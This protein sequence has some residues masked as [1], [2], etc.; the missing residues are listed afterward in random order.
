MNEKLRCFS[1]RVSELKC[2]LAGITYSDPKYYV[3]RNNSDVAVIEYVRSGTGYIV[4]DGKSVEVGAGKVYLLCM[5]ENQEYYSDP[6]NP[7]EKIFINVSGKLAKTLPIDFGLAGMNIFD[8]EE[9]YGI[10]ERVEKIVKK[11]PEENDVSEICSLFFK[12]LF[13][14]SGR[15]QNRKYSSEAVKLKSYLDE[16]YDRIVGNDELARIIYRS[17]DY[18]IKLFFKNFGITPY[19]Y[20]INMKISRSCTLLENTSMAVSVIAETVGYNDPQYFSGL[21]RKKTGMSPSVYRKSK[22]DSAD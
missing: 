5:G 21:F 4:I 13:E 12:L 6:D 16:N 19:E 15:K 1:E 7:W 18:T 9:L 17:K 14:L 2:P 20:Q 8:G 22:K 11:T 3:K 10:F